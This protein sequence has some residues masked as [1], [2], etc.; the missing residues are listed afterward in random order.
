MTAPLAPI[1]PAQPTWGGWGLGWPGVTG[2]GSSSEF[3]FDYDHWD[4][5][6]DQEPDWTGEIPAERAPQ[7]E[8]DTQ[9]PAESFGP[10]PPYPPEP[11]PP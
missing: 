10:P 1:V 3:D 2:G 4:T 9:Q 5:P 6:V 11:R 7:D 8:A